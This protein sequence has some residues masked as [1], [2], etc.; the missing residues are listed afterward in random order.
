[1]EVDERAQRIEVEIAFVGD[2]VIGVVRF[3]LKVVVSAAQMQARRDLEL[4]LNCDPR[5]ADAAA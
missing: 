4:G 5:G 3:I 2:A 1:M